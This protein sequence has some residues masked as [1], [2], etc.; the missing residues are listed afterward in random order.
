MSARQ[1]YVSHACFDDSSVMFSDMKR[2]D[3]TEIL[4]L[5][6]EFEAKAKLGDPDVESVLERALSLPYSDPKTYET[7]AGR[8]IS[9]IFVC[10]K[11]YYR[12]STF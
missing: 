1:A 6:Y 2:K 4:L 7:M 8:I 11:F 12:I 10:V 9:A 5:L 3:T